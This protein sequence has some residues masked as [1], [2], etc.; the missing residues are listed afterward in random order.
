[1]A[2]KVFINLPV[3]DLER[4]K[5]FY[6]ALGYT[7]NPQFTDHN[8]ASMVV[9]D[10]I[11]VML[12]TREFFAQFTNKTII[13]ARTNVQVLVAIDF[14]S[15]AEVDAMIEKV[16]AAGGEETRPVQDLGFMYSRAYADPDGH[17]WELFW[18]NPEHIQS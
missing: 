2:Q 11:Y 1:M 15:K 14:N 3:A 5:E 12:L 7:F 10:T 13:D 18:M 8:A 4:T 16:V 9:S 17:I 6:A